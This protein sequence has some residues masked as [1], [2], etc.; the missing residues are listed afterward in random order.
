MSIVF[1]LERVVAEAEDIRFSEAVAAEGAI[2]FAHACRLGLE[3]I[4]SKRVLSRYRC[5]TSRN[6]RKCLNPDFQRA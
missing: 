6:W 2:V 3:G 1:T 5:G 4:V